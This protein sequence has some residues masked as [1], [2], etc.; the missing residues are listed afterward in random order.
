MKR[1]IGDGML[2][3]TAIVWGSGFVVTAIALEHLSAFQVMAGRFVLATII[4]SVLFG[5]KFKTF[6]KSVIWKGAVIGAILYIGFVLQTV[7]LE[8][9]T[10]SKNAF[11]TAVNVIIVPLIGYFIYKRKIDRHEMLGSIIA[12]IGIGF[13]SLQGSFTINIGD[14]LTLLCAIAFAFD[15]FYTNFFVQKEDALS[16]T[17]VQFITASF[18][19]VTVMFAIGDV[20]T[21]LGKEAILSIIYLGI[22]ST[23]LAYVFQNIG[24]KYTTATRAAIILSTEALFGTILSVLILKEVLTTKMIIGAIL[25]MAAILITELKPAFRRREAL[26]KAGKI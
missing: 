13:L 10:P 4:L 11:L 21:S 8:Y 12:V 19:S 6:T 25:I 20:P 22:F 24:H 15:I 7:G 2:L 14:A 16:L 9:T 3:I 1:Y 17:I 23:T 5:N 26:K 18:L